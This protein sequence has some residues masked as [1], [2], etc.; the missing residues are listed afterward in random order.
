MNGQQIQS[1]PTYYNGI[2]FR[3]RLKARWAMFFDYL[4]VPWF[5]EYEGFELDGVRYLPDFYLP[6]LECWIEI[7]P[8]KPSG[9]ER[10]KCERLAKAT[11]TSTYLFWGIRESGMDAMVVPHTRGRQH[12]ASMGTQVQF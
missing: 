2:E 11:G 4:R 12:W 10:M 6:L 5:Y 8:V 7:K 9:K 3:S 1:L